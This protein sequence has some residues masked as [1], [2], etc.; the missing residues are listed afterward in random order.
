MEINEKGPHPE[1][2]KERLNLARTWRLILI[3]HLGHDMAL[4]KASPD[5]RLYLCV[6]LAIVLQ[7]IL[8]TYLFRKGA[9]DE[10]GPC[11]F[12]DPLITSL[13]KAFSWQKAEKEMW[14]MLYF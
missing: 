2:H 13:H 11:G 1:V 14:R 9:E 7:R 5:R 10:G 6:N 8:L 12:Q 4:R 3:A